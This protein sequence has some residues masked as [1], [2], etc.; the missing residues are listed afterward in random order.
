MA[1]ANTTTDLAAKAKADQDASIKSAPV[2]SAKITQLFNNDRDRL[3]L[4]IRR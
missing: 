3:D 4:V 1:A 2:G